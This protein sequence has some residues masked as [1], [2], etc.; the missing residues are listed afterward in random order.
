M[1]WVDGRLANFQYTGF[2]GGNLTRQ[3]GPRRAGGSHAGTCHMLFGES[4]LPHA[5]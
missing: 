1:G 4:T 5:A 3:T 2:F